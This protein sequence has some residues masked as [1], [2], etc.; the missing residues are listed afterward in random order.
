M[1]IHNKL[2]V[3]EEAV[4]ILKV[5]EVL[6]FSIFQTLGHEHPSPEM[7]CLDF[8]L[9]LRASS[10]L[11]LGGYYRQAIPCLRNWLEMR[12]LG[13]YFGLAEQDKSKYGDWKLGKLGKPEAP[14]G[15]RGPK[16]L[17]S[18]AKFQKADKKV[19]LRDHLRALLGVICLHTWAALRNTIFKQTPIMFRVTY[20]ASVDLWFSLMKRTFVQ[21]AFCM[22]IA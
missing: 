22:I 7:L 13:I 5:E 6:N 3:M 19:R 9:D 4:S 2:E 1:V 15:N 10:D 17:F 20:S 16:R 21:V 11:L 8:P 18:I 14:F 12:L